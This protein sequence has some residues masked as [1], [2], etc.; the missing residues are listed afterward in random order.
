V[1]TIIPSTDYDKLKKNIYIYHVE[2]FNCLGSLIK[3]VARYTLEIKLGNSMAKSASN[4]K[5]TLFI[6]KSD[7]KC[8]E[9]T[10]GKLLLDHSFVW[11]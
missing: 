4:K 9:G 6:S 11:Y 7:L 8:N 10:N 3:S 5:K 2:P 1:R